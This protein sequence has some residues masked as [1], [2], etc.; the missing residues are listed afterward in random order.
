MDAET[1]WELRRMGAAQ[2]EAERE[3]RTLEREGGLRNAWQARSAR[4]KLAGIRKAAR[5]A[6]ADA[7][8]RRVW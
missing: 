3:L 2:V 6:V 8:A 1:V 4:K 7:R 5:R